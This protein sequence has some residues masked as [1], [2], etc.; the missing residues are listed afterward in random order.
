MMLPFCIAFAGDLLINTSVVVAAIGLLTTVILLDV[1]GRS[2]RR[3]QL[4]DSFAASGFSVDRDPGDSRKRVA[5]AAIGSPLL[6]THGSD[7]LKWICT[8][9]QAGRQVTTT[10][11]EYVHHLGR[12]GVQ[13]L[14]AE[15]YLCVGIECGIATD[16]VSI[17]PRGDLEQFAR[18]ALGIAASPAGWRPHIASRFRV[19]APEGSSVVA[20]LASPAAQAVLEAM[21]ETASLYIASGAV[22]IMVAAESVSV[23]LAQSLASHALACAELLELHH[24]DE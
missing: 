15:R 3:P 4:L 9:C 8:S 18:D 13:P 5:F 14:V 23:G 11:Y 1:R 7:K 10:L 12:G 22:G 17:V 21:P 24:D 19:N 2:Q 20:R 16:R 6:L